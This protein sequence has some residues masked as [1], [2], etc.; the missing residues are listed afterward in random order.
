MTILPIYAAL[1]ALL[2]VYLSIQTIRT[3]RKLGIA[4]GHADNP[5]M[6]RVMRVHANFAEYVPFAL[7]LIFL[8]ETLAA[9]PLLIHA[10]GST[11]LLG[12]LSHALGVSQPR[13]KFLLRV[14]G[15]ALT[16]TVIISCAVYIL[17]QAISG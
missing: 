4:L 16:F 1:L 17:W 14:S 11:L 12:R 13:E 9:P 8:V 6:L 7:L 15:M 2:F 10:L 5:Q 3:R